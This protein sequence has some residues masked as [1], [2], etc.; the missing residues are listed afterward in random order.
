MDLVEFIYQATAEFPSYERFALTNQL[1]RAA[2]SI[3]SNIAEGQGRHSSKDFLYFLSV[4]RGSLQE[5]ETQVELAR[6]LNYLDQEMINHAIDLATEV[7][8]LI[9]G[10]CRSLRPLE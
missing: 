3:P 7:A 2:V 1:R 8:K 6:R 9:N 5:V 4:A 10:L